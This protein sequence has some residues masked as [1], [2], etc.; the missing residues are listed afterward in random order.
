VTKRERA[1]T[2]KEK[3]AKEEAKEKEV[4]PLFK[5]SSSRVEMAPI[6]PHSNPMED[7]QVYEVDIDIDMN[8]HT[9]ERVLEETQ[10]DEVKEKFE[11]V[12]VQEK[13]RQTRNRLISLPTASDYSQ[14]NESFQCEEKA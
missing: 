4:R 3:K 5:G 11:L 8:I 10:K 14:V 7:S 2:K 6:V 9:R 13:P 12:K 1:S